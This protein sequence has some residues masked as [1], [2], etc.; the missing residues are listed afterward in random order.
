MPLRMCTISIIASG[1]RAV[2]EPSGVRIV[3]NRD[4]SHSRPAAAAPRWRGIEGADGRA[5]WPMDMEGG[6]TWIAASE[7]GLALALLN[8]NPAPPL[9]ARAGS[10]LRSRG[11]II[12]ELIG[13]D[14]AARTMARLGRLTL[15]H[16]APF[17]LIAVETFAPQGPAIL[18]A[19]WDRTRLEVRRHAREA[20]AWCFVSSGLG[21]HLVQPRLGLFDELVLHPGPTPERQDDFHRHTWPDRPEISVL[22]ARAEARTVSIT[23]LEIGG[24]GELGGWSDG[25]VRME[26]EPIPART[27]VAAAR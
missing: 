1:G 5:I 15:R 10:R 27:G 26:Y 21:D 4:E 11:L 23:T 14:S 3:C 7:A 16:F 8:L 18:E 13:A 17:R 9:R 20:G 2:G 24:G 19:S 6:G 12:P 22:M 25:G